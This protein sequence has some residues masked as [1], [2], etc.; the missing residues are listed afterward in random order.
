MGWAV[1]WSAVSRDRFQSGD[2]SPLSTGEASEAFL[3]HRD[4]VAQSAGGEMVVE[5]WKLRAE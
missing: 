2:A 5:C 1:V 4:T 3:N